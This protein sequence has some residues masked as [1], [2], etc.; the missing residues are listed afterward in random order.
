MSESVLGK[1]AA[2]AVALVALIGVSVAWGTGAGTSARAAEPTEVQIT[3]GSLNWGVKASFR[4]Y[5]GEG[6]ITVAGGVTRAS[7]TSAE[8]PV[9]GFQWPLVSGTFDTESK[10]TVLQFGG[11]VHFSAHE[12][13]L[14]LTIGQP[15]LVLTGAEST[16]YASVKSEPLS[17]GSIVDYGVIPIVSLDLTGKEPTVAGGTTTWPGLTSYL[18][19]EA[20]EPFAGFYPVSQQMDS[21][22]T[23]YEGP[24]GKAPVT[25]EK[26]D[27]PGTAKFAK[28]LVNPNVKP[29]SV[30]PDLAHDVIVV[31][32]QAGAIKAL[33][34][35]TL[36]PIGSAAPVTRQENITNSHSAYD[37]VRGALFVV[38]GGTVHEET[39]DA[40]TSSFTDVVLP[41]AE[42]PTDYSAD[43][44]YN[45]EAEMLAHYDGSDLQTWTRDGASWTRKDFHVD[46]ASY[47]TRMAVDDDGSILL[48]MASTAPMEIMFSEEGGEKVAKVMTLPGS[49][50]DPQATQPLE[51]GQPSQVQ[52]GPDGTAYLASYKGRVWAAQK[53]SD[54][55][56]R[57]SGTPMAPNIGNAFDSAIDPV[58]GTLVLSAQGANRVLAY[59]DGAFAGS[60]II[61]TLGFPNNFPYPY[62][63]VAVDSEHNL[64][65]GSGDS[66][67]GGIW[68]LRRLGLTPTVTTQPQDATT[69]LGL[70]EA[71][72]PV[73]FTVAA[74]GTPAPTLQW[75]SRAGSSDRWTNLAG[76]TAP[77]LELSASVDKSGLQVRAVAT[78]AA[79]ALATDVATL[80][81]QA[82]PAIVVQPES[83]TTVAGTPVTFAVAPS[84]NPYPEVQWQRRDSQ[85]FWVNVEGA[86]SPT[87]TIEEPVTAMS[88][89]TVR[90]R[91][92]NTYGTIYS[93]AVTLTVEAPASGPV[94]VTGGYLDWGVKE[95]FRS[96]V[97][98]P[99]A[100]GDYSAAGG[101]T[102]NGDGTLR[103]PATGG[104]YDAASG[105]TSV[106]LAGSVHFTG[107]AG[108]LEMTFS[109]L[110]VLFDGKGGGTLYAD[111][112]SKPDTTGAAAVAYP[113]VALADLNEAAATVTRSAGAAAWTGIG[114]KLSAAGAPAFAG[115]YQPGQ[116]LDP[117]DLSIAVGGPV[118]D[119]P[120]PTDPGTTEEPGTDPPAERAV[121]GTT[122]TTPAAT[123]AAK[124]TVR[125]AAG[126]IQVRN[127]R[128]V[129]VASISCP[130]GPC[131]VQA[132]K[133][134]R[135]RRAGVTAG[136]RV[137]KPG[138]LH[139]GE[140]GAVK[141]RLSAAAVKLLAGHT[142]R[143]R[144]RVV[145]TAG[146]G[147][148][149]TT[150]VRPQVTVP[151]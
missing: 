112:V 148:R 46:K 135:L 117:A 25:V 2:W 68:K 28:A 54:G 5:V 93:K 103:F 106:R 27:S 108:A 61:P 9:P 22:S 102:E 69:T 30:Y 99:I 110:H 57:Q 81:V 21:V 45:D 56:Y 140:I 116:V 60:T 143:L 145:T 125:V 44:A 144:L 6:G 84:G 42:L 139:S 47:L 87:M 114:A 96:Y 32:E 128:T 76:K 26:W 7:D 80:D 82:A 98:G 34:P 95:S 20:G 83:K 40:G 111:A 33:D 70:G 43:L 150:T 48:T 37:S 104:S 90:A 58:D 100:K 127:G 13:A 55:I 1:V 94:G 18:T 92:H 73:N 124:A 147:T 35:E 78:N 136:V 86:T 67:E 62:H 23:S 75:Q 142:A 91:I 16:L 146:D 39:W 130:A 118:N 66:A 133:A 12:G 24:G 97:R 123:V 11:S 64:Y 8:F 10:S 115:F 119:T 79:G 3:E 107:H 134:L 141:L 38:V 49:Y 149:T 126:R 14:D 41:G 138:T 17:G 120:P 88:G 63:G 101:A 53:G 72:K 71:S 50:T 52:F 77:T 4:R 137:I 65:A 151:A 85:G 15:K 36:Q 19:S 105:V 131:T 89:T 121:T 29:T 132:P 109:A 74:T 31:V 113:G 51:F 129:A 59:H 122:E